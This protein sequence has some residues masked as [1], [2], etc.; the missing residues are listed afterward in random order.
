VILEV[1]Q[2]EKE[3]ERKWGQQQPG[4]LPAVAA[5]V[6]LQMITDLGKKFV[7][8]LDRSDSSLQRLAFTKIGDFLGGILQSDPIGSAMCAE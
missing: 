5:F 8:S 6:M 7:Q 3:K 1:N 2:K 4:L